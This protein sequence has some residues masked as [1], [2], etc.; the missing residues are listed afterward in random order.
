VLA[1]AYVVASSVVAN[2][3]NALIGTGLLVLGVPTYWLG[4][5]RV[6]S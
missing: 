5:R 3:K 2:P 1:A 4:R 6:S